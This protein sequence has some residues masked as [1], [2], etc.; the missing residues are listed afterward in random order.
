[1]LINIARVARRPWRTAHWFTASVTRE[2]WWRPNGL[3]LN[4]ASVEKPRATVVHPREDSGRLREEAGP[5]RR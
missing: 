1:M 2:G 5:G 4:G 3:Q